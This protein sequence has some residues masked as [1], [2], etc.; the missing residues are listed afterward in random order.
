MYNDMQIR[1]SDDNFVM[2]IITLIEAEQIL[3]SG[4]EVYLLN[5]DGSESLANSVQNLYDH[6]WEFYDWK[7]WVEIWFIQDET[8]KQFKKFLERTSIVVLDFQKELVCTYDWEWD[9]DDIGGVETLIQE[10]WHNLNDCHYWVFKN[11]DIDINK[12]LLQSVLDYI[13]SDDDE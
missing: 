12:K 11:D 10:C 2:K 1:L 9:T 7:L 8:N 4:W 13:P 5:D 3:I 6:A